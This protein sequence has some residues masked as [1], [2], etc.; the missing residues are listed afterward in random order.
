[1]SS[2]EIVLVSIQ[3][4][5][6]VLL[7]A[8]LVVSAQRSSRAKQFEERAATREELANSTQGLAAKLA[9]L[10][11]RL[12]DKADLESATNDLSSALEALPK[13]E[14]MKQAT[15]SLA[16]KADLSDATA[17]LAKKS[18][19]Q[20]V[21]RPYPTSADF[22]SLMDSLL[23]R[24]TTEMNQRLDSL[25]KE[26]ASSSETDNGVSLPL[27]SNGASPITEK[28]VDAAMALFDASEDLITAAAV[29]L[30]E[31]PRDGGVSIVDHQHRCQSNID[32][33]LSAQ[34]AV[35]MLFPEG[36]PVR[37][38]ADSVCAATEQL[39]DALRANYETMNRAALNGA[40]PGRTSAQRLA[41]R[42][43]E[44]RAVDAQSQ[45]T[46]ALTPVRDDLGNA[47]DQ[48]STSLNTQIHGT[49]SVGA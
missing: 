22:S 34:R 45:Y 46:S 16:K 19:L 10:E 12:A 4:F 11:A 9:E 23:A 29:P 6:A 8:L 48:Y 28:S 33:V 15:E 20:D 5:T 41:F 24:Q 44:Q 25:A 26:L 30:S 49:R 40:D 35:Q 7:V 13:T 14:D 38:S 21:L 27:G 42:Q 43:A 2:I 3:A 18:D 37:T 32:K 17:S 47:F 1:M 39:R 36:S 31:L